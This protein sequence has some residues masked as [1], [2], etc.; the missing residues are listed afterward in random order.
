[1]D[2]PKSTKVEKSQAKWGGGKPCDRTKNGDSQHVTRF[3][4]FF[5]CSTPNRQ[6]LTDYLAK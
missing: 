3:F 6:P 5:Y 4:L 1:M 2:R